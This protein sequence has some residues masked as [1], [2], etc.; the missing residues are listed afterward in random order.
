MD[1]RLFEAV[2]WKDMRSF[3]NVV[4]KNV[5]ILKQKSEVTGDTALHLAVRN[6]R[7]FMVKKI[8]KLWPEAAAEENLKKETPFHE[9]C[10]EGEA[11]ILMLLLEMNPR[12][13]S[14]LG[15]QSHS[16]M[17]SAC[18]HGHLDVVK[19]LFKQPWLRNLDPAACFLEA[20]SKGH[21]GNFQF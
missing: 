20:A 21:L 3:M 9:A 11:E 6:G 18:S 17:F 5:E 19:I 14:E 2:R 8:L 16:L 13:S 1:P 10:K 12:L 7:G 15:H 4:G